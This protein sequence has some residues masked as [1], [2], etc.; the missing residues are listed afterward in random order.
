MATVAKR[1]RPP[2]AVCPTARTAVS[3]RRSWVLVAAEAIQARRE[4]A[5]GSEVKVGVAAVS[6]LRRRW[7]RRLP[8]LSTIRFLRLSPQ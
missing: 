5:G 6:V 3:R 4:A 7:R 8:I 2:V 1:P